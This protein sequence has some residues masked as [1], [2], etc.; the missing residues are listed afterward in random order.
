VSWRLAW[1]ERALKDAE[2]LDR[3][4]R[5]RVV[6][7]LEKLAETGQGD[8]RRL[9]GGDPEWRLRVG[10]WRVRFVFDYAGK[11]IQVLRVLPRSSAYRK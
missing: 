5:E 1:T 10:D 7:A 8:I 6:A 11:I 2:R 9:G 3:T 4:V